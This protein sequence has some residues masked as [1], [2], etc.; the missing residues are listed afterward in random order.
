VRRAILAVRWVWF[1]TTSARINGLDLIP[2]RNGAIIIT[3]TGLIASTDVEIRLSSALVRVVLQERGPFFAERD[4]LLGRGLHLGH[5]DLTSLARFGEFNLTG[6]ASIDLG[7]RSSLA[8]V[9]LQLPDVFGGDVTAAATLKATNAN[10]LIPDSA[11]MSFA[12]LNLGAF[13][14]KEGDLDYSSD[15]DLWHGDLAISVPGTVDLSGSIEFRH[16]QLTQADV[17]ANNLA[18]T[19]IPL[20]SSGLYLQALEGSFRHGDIVKPPVDGLPE[21]HFTAEVDG[22]LDVSTG[23]KVTGGSGCGT[24][25]DIDA[26]PHDNPSFGMHRYAGD[27]F[28]LEA[29]AGA[30]LACV[31]IGS[32]SFLFDTDGLIEV[33]GHVDYTRAGLI[34]FS[35]DLKAKLNIYST[36]PFRFDFDA[37]A[38]LC[39]N[40]VCTG[41][42]DGEALLSDRGS[43]V[44]VGVEVEAGPVALGHVVL[45]VRRRFRVASRS[46]GERRE[47]PAGASSD[48]GSYLVA[49]NL[50]PRQVR[51]QRQPI[52]TLDLERHMTFEHVLDVRQPSTKH[53]PDRAGS[54][55]PPP[56]T[57]AGEAGRGS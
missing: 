12:G 48:R 8:S 51:P 42:A 19:G 39:I 41:C 28:R 34:G 43:G 33:A 5:L 20:G 24:L 17:L 44:S 14:I 52:D 10:G 4:W 49:G 11:H 47:M 31:P 6:Q 26:L 9:N 15:G 45:G 35:G 7:Y 32:S 56:R 57:P 55:G 53:D 2:R 1:T 16:G 25:I 29:S 46:V 21:K 27:G 22:G 37:G 13:T 50:Q 30:R 3:D 38:N 40:L 36:D 54:A 23:Q 18:G